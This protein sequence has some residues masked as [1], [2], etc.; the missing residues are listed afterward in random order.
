[1]QRGKVANINISE[2]PILSAIGSALGLEKQKLSPEYF[3]CM[4]PTQ[5]YSIMD[6]MMQDKVYFDLENENK[7]I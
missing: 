3:L 6:Q 2:N 1:M 7:S 4:V 5:I